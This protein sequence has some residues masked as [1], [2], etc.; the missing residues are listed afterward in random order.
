MKLRVCGTLQ[1]AHD[2]EVAGLRSQITALNTRL[3][4]AAAAQAAAETA[5][6]IE[7]E[8]TRAESAATHGDEV[9]ALRAKLAERDVELE[10]ANAVKAE[11]LEICDEKAAQVIVLQEKL[12]SSW[13]P[14]TGDEEGG[15]GGGG[16]GGGGGGDGRELDA[17]VEAAAGKRAP[18]LHRRS[19][20]Y[21][22]HNHNQ[23]T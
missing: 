8:R 5:S 20:S 23:D 21:V 14:P 4:S 13:M 12:A 9:A 19:T 3:Q 17:A 16:E 11:A 1:A 22:Q 10:E 2:A 18:R 7:A 6:A 15:G